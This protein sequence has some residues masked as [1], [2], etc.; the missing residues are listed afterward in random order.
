MI[1]LLSAVLHLL[2]RDWLRAAEDLRPPG[3]Q[4]PLIIPP[5]SQ[6]I[7]DAPC[8][9]PFGL[10]SV[11]SQQALGCLQTL[12]RVVVKQ[13]IAGTCLLSSCVFSQVVSEH[14]RL[15]GAHAMKA[16]IFARGPISCGIDATDKLD[17]YSGGHI[18]AEYNPLATINHIVSV[19]G[20][21][22]EDG[23]EYWCATL[24]TTAFQ[25]GQD[26]LLQE[27]APQLVT[28]NVESL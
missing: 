23:V 18:F 1:L 19:L 5:Q 20:W 14:G 12:S 8:F 15:H 16:E 4:P 10:C 9:T 25:Y 28:R 6:K 7:V 26:C 13:G 22:E 2:A 24:V 21:G 11:V 3:V 27:P 17:A